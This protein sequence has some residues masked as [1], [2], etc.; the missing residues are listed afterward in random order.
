MHYVDDEL[1]WSA[2]LSSLPAFLI[3]GLVINDRLRRSEEV[4]GEQPADVQA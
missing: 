1:L 2:L 3:T 4:V